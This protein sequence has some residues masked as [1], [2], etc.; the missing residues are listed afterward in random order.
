MRGLRSE[1]AR[2]EG[3]T[4]IELM[5]ALGVSMM[6]ATAVLALF[7]GQSRALR[8]SQQTMETQDNVRVAMEMLARD[9]RNVGFFIPPA[10]A[11]RV[12][13]DCGNSAGVD[14]DTGTNQ[15]TVPGATGS[16]IAT[17]GDIQGSNQPDGCPNGSDRIA[18]VYRPRLDFVQGS[19]PNPGQSHILNLPCPN[20]DCTVP[21]VLGGIS[22]TTCGTTIESDPMLVC[23]RNDPL[24]C[25]WVTVQPRPGASG[26]AACTGRPTCQVF[27]REHPGGNP[28]TT[29]ARWGSIGG[30]DNATFNSILHRTYQLRDVD[31]DGSTEL[32][33]SD[34]VGSLLTAGAAQDAT[35]IPI[36]NYID[37]FQVAVAFSDAP[38]TFRNDVNVWNLGANC[39]AGANDVCLSSTTALPVAVRVTLVA[40]TARKLFNENGQIIQGYR[41]AVEDNAPAPV[42][43]NP[44]A[45]VPGGFAHCFGTEDCGCGGT[46]QTHYAGCTG[47]GNA[48]GFRRRIVTRTIS[49]RNI[50]LSAGN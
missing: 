34:D 13:N 45:A 17:D 35:W 33:Y 31:G 12:E 40:R 43:Y 22:G 41:P 24:S 50:G 46:T 15:F 20:L 4:L 2:R 36:A 23:H 8:H 7:V 14:F 30:Q 37:D 9:L 44:L 39:T 18:V 11:L 29:P 42:P 3:F 16:A 47:N 19:A 10:A 27:L 32:A 48:E 28:F 49:L 38:T 21:F 25:Q 1:P 6:L 26:C 5:I